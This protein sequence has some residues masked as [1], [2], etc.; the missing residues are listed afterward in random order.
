MGGL[1]GLGG[2]GGKGGGSGAGGISPAQQA[3]SQFTF[4]QN[5]LANAQQFGSHG[6]GHSTG[7]T[8]ADA[9]AYM[10]QAL[11]ESQMSQADTQAMNAFNQQQKGQLSSG[12]GGLGSA[13]GGGFSSGGSFG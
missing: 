9:G 4:G 7:L 1:G 3:L 10:G 5:A 13:L 8:Q 11:Q 12:I 6:M 2:G